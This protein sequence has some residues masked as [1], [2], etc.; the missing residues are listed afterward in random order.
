[1]FF[2]VWFCCCVLPQSRSGFPCCP[3]L[4]RERVR[5]VRLA[6]GVCVLIVA[7]CCSCRGFLRL[8]IKTCGHLSP[9]V[10]VAILWFVAV[11][12]VLS[13]KWREGF[14]TLHGRFHPVH[15][16]PFLSIVLSLANIGIYFVIGESVAANY[17]VFVAPCVLL[18]EKE[19]P[20]MLFFDC[21]AV[22]CACVSCFR[23]AAP[24]SCPRFSPSQPFSPF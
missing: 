17:V 9:V 24:M 22:V 12:A 20:T 21:E 4:V 19:S 3:L 13:V 23:S 1:M 8:S 6:R 7:A 18:R 10:V 14:F 5:V 15:E 16:R 2:T 11:A